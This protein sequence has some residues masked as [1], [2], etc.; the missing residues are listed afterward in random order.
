MLCKGRFH[1]IRIF[2]FLF[3][4]KEILIFMGFFFFFFFLAD[5]GVC[6]RFFGVW[7]WRIFVRLCA[8]L[9]IGLGVM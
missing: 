9:L 7:N 1:Y 5:L 8:V 3:V 2:F 4:F 6:Y